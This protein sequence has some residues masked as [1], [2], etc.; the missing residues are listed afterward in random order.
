MEVIVETCRKND[1]QCFQ[2]VR[3]CVFYNFYTFLQFF[4]RRL[5]V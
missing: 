1:M 4:Y 5:E 2:W 3:C